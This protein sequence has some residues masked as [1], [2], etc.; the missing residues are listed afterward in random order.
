LRKLQ[1]GDIFRICEWGSD[2]H[3]LDRAIVLL[4]VADP[5]A[6]REELVRLPIGQRDALL[7]R[8]R[9]E[10]FGERFD[11]QVRCPKCGERLEFSVDA[12]QLLLK[13]P[14]SD[15]DGVLESDGWSLRYR[16]PNSADLAFVSG[17]SNT[18]EA[19]RALLSRCVR[20]TDGNGQLQLVKDVPL[21]LLDQVVER[22]GEEDPQ[23][24]I[25]FKLS[26][27][28]CKNGW[29]S[30]F[31]I[32]SYFWAELEAYAERLQ[33]DVHYIARAYGWPEDS[34]LGMSAKRRQRYLE[35]I[36]DARSH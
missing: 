10:T 25:T 20:A 36:S 8:L 31:D 11:I 6:N 27:S 2:K 12:A 23:A 7:L 16:L 35:L 30:A 26:C 17:I 3:D 4:R 15:Q 18:V 14:D 19:R 24:D 5:S 29:R 28:S 34:I 13:H 9:A 32:L 21:D 1:P 22:M 33:D